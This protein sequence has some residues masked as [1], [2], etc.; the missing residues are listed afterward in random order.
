MHARLWGNERTMADLLGSSSATL[1]GLL[2]R[3][4]LTAV[5]AAA[6]DELMVEVGSHWQQASPH[7]PRLVVS[8]SACPHAG[9]NHCPF[10]LPLGKVSLW[11]SVNTRKLAP[12]AGKMPAPESRDS[13]NARDGGESRRIPLYALLALVFAWAVLSQLQ[14]VA[15]QHVCVC[16][17]CVVCVCVC[18]CVNALA[19]REHAWGLS[20]YLW[21]YL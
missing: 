7:R 11:L 10:R 9:T 1:F 5:R 16:V 20:I 17:L 6:V 3:L 4:L 15:M 14:L 2:A 18:L 13:A 19:C 21:I 12:G 8:H